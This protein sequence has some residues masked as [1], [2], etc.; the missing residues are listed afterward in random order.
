MLQR[1]TFKVKAAA[2]THDTR[3]SR[4]LSKLLR[5]RL[6]DAGLTDCLRPDGF[7]P[8][9][10]VLACLPEGATVDALRRVVEDNDK[11][12]FALLEE[13]GA[14][15]VRANQGHSVSLGLDDA[16]MMVEV[17]A[18]EADSLVCVHGTFLASWPAIRAG[19]LSRMKRRHVHFAA[20]VD[21]SKVISGMRRTA[22]V[23]VYLD[24][25]KAVAAGLKLYR[26]ANGVLL[27]PG[28]ERG[29][30]SP[31]FFARVVVAATGEALP[32]EDADAGGPRPNRR[33]RR[34]Q[35]GK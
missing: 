18:D 1:W 14:L 8:V 25:A 9:D 20:A 3:L 29:V 22:E 16:A 12:R 5:H 33:E 19:G 6:H 4:Q 10:R 28:D 24:A 34:K 35:L 26:S 7:V 31:A 15:Y 11:Q 13:A 21:A 17:S 2:P 32:V 27:S 30:V 23:L